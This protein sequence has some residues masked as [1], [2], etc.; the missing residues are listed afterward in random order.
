MGDSSQALK[1]KHMKKM[2]TMLVT[3]LCVAVLYC[4]DAERLEELEHICGFVPSDDLRR[5][6][7]IPTPD[8]IIVKYHITTNQLVAD[9]RTP[10]SARR[11]KEVVLVVSKRTY[12]QAA[13][14]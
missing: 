13:S 2:M 8:D 11:E 1:G 3:A 9:S 10:R 6:Q 7:V 14:G 5:P 12:R 4:G